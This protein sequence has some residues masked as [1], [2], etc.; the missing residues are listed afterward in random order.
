MKD[1]TIIFN[2]EGKF[3]VATCV[4]LGVVSQGKTI[5]EARDNIKEAIELY[6]EETPQED[7]HF[8]E[9]PFVSTVKVR[10]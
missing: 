3:Y 10:A 9:A 7:Y 6:L 4:E 1:F 2:K 8:D 5:E